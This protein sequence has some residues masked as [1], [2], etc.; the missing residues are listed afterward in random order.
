MKKI[1]LVLSSLPEYGGEHQYDVVVADCIARYA[2]KGN[3]EILAACTNYYWQRWCRKNQIEY[4][5]HMWEGYGLPEMEKDRK[6]PLLSKIYHTFLTKE[7]KWLRRKKIDLI[8]CMM[9]S[10]IIPNYFIKVMRP[11]HDIMHRYESRFREIKSSYHDRESLFR[12]VADSATTILVDSELGKKQFEECYIE[13]KSRSD[14]N[15]EVLPF[16]APE[17]IYNDEEEYIDVPEKFVFYPAQ[18]WQHKNHINLVKAIN[19]LK[20]QVRDIHLVLVGSEKNSL[21]EVKKYIRDN[22]L[23]DYVSIKGFVSNGQMTYLYKHALGMIMPSFFGPT[24]IPPLEAMALGCPAAVANRYA[25]PEQVGDAGLQ[26]DPEKPQEIAE[27]IVKLWTDEDLR[28]S[29]SKAG[30]QRMEKW[31]KKDFEHKLM[32][33]VISTLRI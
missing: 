21:S 18:F 20:A 9:Q 33:I 8:F 15:I 11:V 13:E 27:C 23:E 25:M 12:Y 3:Y 10:Q 28:E 4:Y 22:E 7:G 2:K 32:Q 19:I 5:S 17:H 30:I 16:I 29:L 14:L 26:F 31:T 24:N 1:L 6:Y